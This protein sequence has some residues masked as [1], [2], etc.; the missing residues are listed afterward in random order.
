M[1]NMLSLLC[2]A[3]T[4]FIIGCGRSDANWY[5]I[6]GGMVNLSRANFVHAWMKITIHWRETKDMQNLGE[7]N[8]KEFDCPIT[9]ANVANLK[10]FIREH[11]KSITRY[12]DCTAT[13]KIDQHK[14][15]LPA[16]EGTFNGPSDLEHMIDEWLISA[17]ALFARLQ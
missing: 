3:S 8:K 1:K 17:E 16:I 6:D 10:K 14:I 12:S 9:E 11:G 13:L 2:V 7:E 5:P 4:A 15:L